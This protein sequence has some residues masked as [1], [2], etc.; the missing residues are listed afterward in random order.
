VKKTTDVNQI[1]RLYD[2]H[3]KARGGT[4]IFK[5]EKEKLSFPK[6]KGKKSQKTFSKVNANPTGSDG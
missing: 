1:N 3:V 6:N 2:L 4:F 5:K